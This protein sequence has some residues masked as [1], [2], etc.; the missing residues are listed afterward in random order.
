M[1]SHFA[2]IFEKKFNY[3]LHS[4]K[5]SKNLNKINNA[6]FYCEEM[7]NKFEFFI[8]E[9]IND[10]PL[11]SKFAYFSKEE[12]IENV[13]NFK[14]HLLFLSLIKYFFINENRMT[15]LNELRKHIY[16]Y[17]LNLDL[18]DCDAFNAPLENRNVL[19][20]NQEKILKFVRLCDFESLVKI[21]ENLY[22]NLMTSSNLVENF[23]YHEIILKVFI[24]K[25][26]F[27]FQT[28]AFVNRITS[29][30]LIYF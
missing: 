12:K 18:D 17:G 24:I 6:R 30:Y 13:K 8:M 1:I 29:D 2:E 20:I 10:D 5:Y 23:I 28:Q 25:V 4:F 11:Q 14:M 27:F 26:V 9:M 16:S 19:G 22:K 3:I 15:H 7:M 21:F